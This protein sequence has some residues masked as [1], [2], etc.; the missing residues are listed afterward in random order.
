[1]QRYFFGQNLFFQA[2]YQLIWKFPTFGASFKGM[3]MLNMEE[4]QQE[5][6]EEFS[7][8]TDWMDKNSYLLEVVNELPNIDTAET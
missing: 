4:V 5:I 6:I 1:M 8:Y 2:E 7:A 3:T